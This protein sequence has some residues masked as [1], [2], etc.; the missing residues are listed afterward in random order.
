SIRVDADF[1]Q[2]PRF[3]RLSGYFEM[4]FAGSTPGNIAVTTSG[5]G[6]RLRLAFAEV[7]Y[8]ETFFLAAGQAFSL[9]TA[10]K[11]QLSLW[12]A[13]VE[14][15]QAGGPNYVGGVFR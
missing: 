7:Q 5:A 13:G 6:F 1:P 15:S 4:D 2:G 11:D 10:P 8:G 9:M 3:R 14:V 12:P